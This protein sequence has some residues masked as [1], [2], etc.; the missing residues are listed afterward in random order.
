MYS[1]SIASSVY[2]G[3]LWGA[4]IGFSFSIGDRYG[5]RI[6]PYTHLR[7]DYDLSLFQK[8]LVEISFFT[9][10]GASVGGVVGL[11]KGIYDKCAYKQT[12][13]NLTNEGHIF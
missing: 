10:F 2:K 12:I 7:H 1:P 8:D 9:I 5:F 13:D 11:I 4:G 6:N 3:A